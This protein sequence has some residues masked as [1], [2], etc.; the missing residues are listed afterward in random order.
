MMGR[1][2]RGG[3]RMLFCGGRD[4]AGTALLRGLVAVAC[5]EG[6]EGDLG[7]PG[8]VGRQG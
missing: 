1:A 4:K 3:G 7:V 5:A 6:A 2:G 8:L